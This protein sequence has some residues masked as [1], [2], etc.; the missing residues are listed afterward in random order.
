MSLDSSPAVPVPAAPGPGQGPGSTAI[1]LPDTKPHP[2]PQ[3]L[4]L[5]P[6]SGPGAV[7]AIL[8]VLV[9]ALAFLLASMPA[10]NSDLWLHLASGR[11]WDQAVR[12][13]DPFASTTSG[14]LWVNHSWLTDV[15]LYELYEVG[16]GRALVVAKCVVV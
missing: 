8:V 10:R 16:G 5:N 2:G 1:V 12:G 14:L 13:T 6:A 9:A 3:G 11:S 4:G 7:D 15:C